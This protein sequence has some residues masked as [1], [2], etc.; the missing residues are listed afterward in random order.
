M[1]VIAGQ[2]RLDSREYKKI[3]IVTVVN[4]TPDYMNLNEAI[5]K[6]RILIKSA[7]GKFVD[8]NLL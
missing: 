5:S 3:G 6:S 7:T 4:C 1:A 8:E 2:V